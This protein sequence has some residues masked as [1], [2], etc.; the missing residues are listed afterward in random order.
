MG[1]LTHSLDTGRLSKQGVSKLTVPVSVCLRA[2]RRVSQSPPSRPLR[3]SRDKSRC[4]HPEHRNRRAEKRRG[5]D[6]CTLAPVRSQTSHRACPLSSVSASVRA[7]CFGPVQLAMG[8]SNTRLVQPDWCMAKMRMA[9]L[10][11]TLSDFRTDTDTKPCEAE[12]IPLRCH[13]RTHLCRR[14][15]TYMYI[16]TYQRRGR[17][18]KL[19]APGGSS[20]DRGLLSVQLY[21]VYIFIRCLVSPWSESG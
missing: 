14:G 3:V 19:S 9:S 10:M 11:S 16:C 21:H 12:H 1:T 5:Q 13:P 8:W 6:S 18:L 2:Y 20:N 15:Y 7:V 17:R 4:I